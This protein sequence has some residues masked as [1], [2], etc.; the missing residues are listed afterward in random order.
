MSRG[1]QTGLPALTFE[2]RSAYDVF[3][4]EVNRKKNM[5]WSIEKKKTC[6]GREIQSWQQVMKQPKEGSEFI[7]NFVLKV[8]WKKLSQWFFFLGPQICV[9]LVKTLNLYF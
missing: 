9:T 8:T 7:E 1:L 5:E 3:F 6:C 2:W 4:A